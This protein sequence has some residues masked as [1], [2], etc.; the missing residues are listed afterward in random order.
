VVFDPKKEG[1]ITFEGM[2]TNCDWSPFE[3]FK[4]QGAPA[5]TFSRGQIVAEDGKF[6][7]KVGH[8][9]FVKRKPFGNLD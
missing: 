3:G 1:T 2:Q 7:G 6:T 4:I 5:Y 8:G 9:A